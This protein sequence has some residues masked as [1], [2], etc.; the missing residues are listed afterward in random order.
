MAS[1]DFFI[2]V[3]GGRKDGVHRVTVSQA[4]SKPQG[5]GYFVSGNDFGCSRDYANPSKVSCI[6]MLLAEH[7]AKLV[8]GV[9]ADLLETYVF[10]L[11]KMGSQRTFLSMVEFAMTDADAV[12]EF[13]AWCTLN[14]D[15]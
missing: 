2:V 6:R 5:M 12:R 8:R 3:S 10:Q 14:S 15:G 13:D 11:Y 9:R 1:E 4:H 7:G